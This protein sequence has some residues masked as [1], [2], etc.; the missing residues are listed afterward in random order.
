MSEFYT[1]IIKDFLGV[2]LDGS[3]VDNGRISETPTISKTNND[4]VQ[5]PEPIILPPPSFTTTNQVYNKVTNVYNN[6]QTIYNTTNININVNVSSSATLPPSR[7]PKEGDNQ[8]ATQ[9]PVGRSITIQNDIASHKF[10]RL[11]WNPYSKKE[12]EVRTYKDVNLSNIVQS[13]QKK[14][15]REFKSW[16]KAQTSAVASVNKDYLKTESRFLKGSASLLP[17]TKLGGDIEVL[18]GVET[19]LLIA[20]IYRVR[21]YNAIMPPCD[22][23][24]TKYKRIEQPQIPE[25]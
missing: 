4:V 24:V 19:L 5:P 21:A 17:S 7:L 16:Y 14:C 22:F 18:F 13:N 9:T 6:S 8:V 11:M 10:G 2:V 23:L 3:P 20:D 1:W 15:T 25:R 12:Y